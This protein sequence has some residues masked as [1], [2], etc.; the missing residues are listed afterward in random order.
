MTAVV[1]TWTHRATIGGVVMSAA[2]VPEAH[3][4]LGVGQ[5]SVCDLLLPLPL[6]AH[7]VDGATVVLEASLNGAWLSGPLFT[8]T[9]RMPDRAL[10]A[11]GA[12]AH[13]RCEGPMH[14]MAYPLGYDVTWTGGAK[15]APVTIVSSAVH[16]GDDTIAWYDDTTPVGIT[17]DVTVTPPADADFAWVAGLHHGSNSYDVSVGD[18][19]TK[20]W[21]RVEVRQSGELRGYAN[22]PV[23]NEQWSSELDYT[24]R[25]NWDA[26]EVY[27]AARIRVADGDVTFRFKSGLKPGTSQRDEYEIDDVTYQTAGKQTIRRI[28][29]GMMAKSGLTLAQRDVYQI[30]DLSGATISLG[31]NGLVDAGQVR[32]EDREQPLAWVVRVL[33][34]FGFTI[35]D[36]PDGVVRMRPFRGSPTG[37]AVQTFSETTNI[38]SLPRTGTDPRNVY[39]SVLVRGA[40][41]NDQEGKRFAYRYR[42][43]PGDVV[44]ND[45]IPDPPGEH[46]LTLSNNLLVSDEL[47]EQAGEIAE[48]N[49]STAQMIEWDTWPVVVRPAQVVQVTAPTIGFDGKLFVQGI[50]YDIDAGGYRMAV[51]GWAGTSQPFSE[52]PDPNPSETDIEP[53]DPRPDD[54][55]RPYDPRAGVS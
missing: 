9:V 13:V 42:T 30:T 43:D 48:A 1:Q 16:L 31:G 18:K 5:V 50:R 35:F 38:L 6:P 10:S 55:W 39:N 20:H 37:S 36:S 41:G 22:L 32:I 19:T 53:D 23:S 26:F 12:V 29:R 47:C 34:L 54:E 27:V 15:T 11:S 40:S 14:R 49:N 7:V 45:L 17:H 4:T 44:A 28:V 33:E 25:D 51:S 2:S 46:L 52:T 3:V 21:S 24:D 8:G